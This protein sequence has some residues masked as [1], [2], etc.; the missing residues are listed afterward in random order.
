MP[1]KTRWSLNPKKWFAPISP[2]T[3]KREKKD[4]PLIQ[5]LP[6]TITVA[7]TSSLTTN[8]VRTS[9]TKACTK[10]TPAT[11]SCD[12]ENTHT[13]NVVPITFVQLPP[14]TIRRERATAVLPSLSF[15]RPTTFVPIHTE[16]TIRRNGRCEKT[17]SIDTKRP[18]LPPI[19]LIFSTLPTTDPHQQKTLMHP[20]EM[21]ILTMSHRCLVDFPR[22]TPEPV[23][24]T[25]SLP[26]SSLASSLVEES[27]NNN[28]NNNKSADPLPGEMCDTINDNPESKEQLLTMKVLSIE[29]LAESET[30]VTHVQSRPIIHHFQTIINNSTSQQQQQMSAPSSP[31]SPSLEDVFEDSQ[32]FSGA[33]TITTTVKRPQSS[34]IADKTTEK[35]IRISP[36]PPAAIDKTEFVRIAPATYRLCAEQTEQLSTSPCLSVS[37]FVETCLSDDSLRPAND[38]AC[39]AK[40]P[41]GSST[42]QINKN[43]QNDLRLIVDGCIRPM[44]ISIGQNRSMKAHQRSKRISTNNDDAQLIIEDITDKLLSSIDYPIYAQHQR[45]Y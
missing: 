3:Q 42:E 18:S 36:S 7:R 40:L 27:T 31:V 34:S 11:E 1:T 38:E 43:I 15:T 2:L 10:I 24:K 12:L 6:A 28:N 26:N 4:N 23:A 8:A 9:K 13:S 25:P 32:T 44:A 35:R 22:H 5:S 19:P 45:C 21:S 33:T 30:S 16:P 39:Y 41:C 14:F 20:A 17:L 37:S 29:S